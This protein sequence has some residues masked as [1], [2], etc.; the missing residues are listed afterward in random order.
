MMRP[1]LFGLVLAAASPVMAA[2]QG[3]VAMPVSGGGHI[4]AGP[5][6]SAH[7]GFGRGGRWS[8]RRPGNWR[9]GRTDGRRG[10]QDELGG[11]W[12]VGIAGEESTA[13][14]DGFFSDGEAVRTAA[15][16]VRYEY[17]R[18]YPFDFYRQGRRR[19]AR[20]GR[21]A[22]STGS[23]ATAAA[24]SRCGFAAADVAAAQFVRKGPFARGLKR[25]ESARGSLTPTSADPRARRRLPDWRRAPSPPGCGL[26]RA[27]ARRSL[28]SC[29]CSSI[30][31]VQTPTAA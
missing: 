20:R 30:R 26:T 2:P 16:R 18:G 1:I 4:G 21:P 25:V 29:P 24:Q 14:A 10:R 3:M 7:F 17:D 22:T 9:G 11:Y 15:G 19:R 12:G 27:P 31:P 8:A 23:A 28:P 6:F 5:G 13:F